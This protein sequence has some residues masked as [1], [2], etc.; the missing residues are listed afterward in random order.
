[1]QLQQQLQ[2]QQQRP[3]HEPY[4]PQPPYKRKLEDRWDAAVPPEVWCDEDGQALENELT[5]AFLDGLE[6]YSNAGSANT[7]TNNHSGDVANL[8][9]LYDHI[10][11]IPE[12]LLNSNEQPETERVL[13][14]RSQGALN[15]ELVCEEVLQPV[16]RAGAGEASCSEEAWPPLQPVRPPPLVDHVQWVD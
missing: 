11:F 2:Q 3:L 1:M 6:T 7:L 12:G 14:V 8:D 5:A 16:R 10:D 15:A 13:E 9:D 4:V